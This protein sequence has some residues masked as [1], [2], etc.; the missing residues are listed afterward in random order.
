MYYGAETL[1]ML[2]MLKTERSMLAVPFPDHFR[3]IIIIII[4]FLFQQIIK[5]LY[6]TKYNYL[7][8]LHENET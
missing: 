2:R 7:H 6:R 1:A 3:I 8:T 4:T 5:S